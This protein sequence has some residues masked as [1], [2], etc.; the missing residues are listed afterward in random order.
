MEEYIAA[1]KQE[2]RA[3]LARMDD[4]CNSIVSV[5]LG[6]GTPTALSAA[7]LD[8]LLDFIFNTFNLLGV[9][10]YHYRGVPGFDA[11]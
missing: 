6:G 1:V 9:A 3:F 2:M 8:G 7:A 5:Q 4:H 11:P 10:G